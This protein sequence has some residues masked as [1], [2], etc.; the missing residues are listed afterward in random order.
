MNI[1]TCSKMK[2]IFGAGTYTS[3]T[4]INWAMIEMM[5]NPSI[6]SKAQAEVRKILRGKETFGEIDV[7]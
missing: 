6:F 3:S 1:V 7:D 2:D 4:T 5:K